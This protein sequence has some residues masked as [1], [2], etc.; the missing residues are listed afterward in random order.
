ML[1]RETRIY[2]ADQVYSSEKLNLL[3]MNLKDSLQVEE[4]KPGVVFDLQESLFCPSSVSV[5]FGAY[6]QKVGKKC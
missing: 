2:R 3:W 1:L 5:T 6:V 4:L